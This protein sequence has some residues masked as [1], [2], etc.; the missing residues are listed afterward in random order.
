MKKIIAILAFFTISLLSTDNAIAQTKN[1]FAAVAKKNTHDFVKAAGISDGTKQRSIYNAYM[2]RE[3][4]L[5]ALENQ[6]KKADNST[7]KKAIMAEFET[8]LKGILTETEYAQYLKF[9]AK[10]S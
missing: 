4:K 9:E 5:A 6:A 10:K 7:A 2:V 3:R 1:N 8:K